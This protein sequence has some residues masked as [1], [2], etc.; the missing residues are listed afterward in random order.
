MKNRLANQ[1]H[2][3]FMCQIFLYSGTYTPRASAH[4]KL[5]SIIQEKWE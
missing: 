3:V 4:P 5:F 1:W 2:K